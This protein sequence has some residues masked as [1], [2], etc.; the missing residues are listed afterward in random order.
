[1]LEPAQVVLLLK[2]SAGAPSKPL[3]KAGERVRTGQMIGEAP[4]GALGVPLHA[5]FNAVVT[6]VSPDRI[7]LSRAS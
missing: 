2:Q 4:T 6:A 7:H 5:P 3:V 1:V